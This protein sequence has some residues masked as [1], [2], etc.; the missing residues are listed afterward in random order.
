MSRNVN[1]FVGALLIAL[2]G[3]AAASAQQ[4]KPVQQRA[5]TSF[6]KLELKRPTAKAL[7]S[8]RSTAPSITASGPAPALSRIIVFAVGSTQ[9]GNWEYM[10]TANQISTVADHGGT[11]LLAVTLEVGYGN[12]PV[13]KMNSVLLPASK[14]IQTDPACLVNGYYVTNCSSGQPYIAFYR[15]WDLS[16]NQS[17]RFTYQNTSAVSPIRT[18][19]TAISIR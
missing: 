3:S 16:G 19:S 1:S 13:A 4:Q 7:E 15:Y 5:L 2:V 6:G 11:Q 10:A 9:Y 14:N 12:N 17:G 18:I 8:G